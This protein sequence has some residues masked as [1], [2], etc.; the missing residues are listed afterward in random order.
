M[1]DE[2]MSELGANLSYVMNELCF[3]KMEGDWYIY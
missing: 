2:E 1:T 3:I